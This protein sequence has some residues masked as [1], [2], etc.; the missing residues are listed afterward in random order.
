MQMSQHLYFLKLSN[1]LKLLT[2]NNTKYSASDFI[3]FGRQQKSWGRVFTED[4][5]LI[6]KIMWGKWP[7]SFLSHPAIAVSKNFTTKRWLTL[8]LFTI[9]HQ[10][11]FSFWHWRS[12]EVTT[13]AN[14][15]WSWRRLQHVFS[16][17]SV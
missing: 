3:H 11:T 16:T 2:K 1:C 6:L 13:P 17:S 9:K 5:S 8:M 15:C 7:S 4:I 10:V 12:A 14:I